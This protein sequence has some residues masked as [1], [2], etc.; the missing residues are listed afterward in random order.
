MKL[1]KKDGKGSDFEI[2]EQDELKYSFIVPRRSKLGVNIC[3][4]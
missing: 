4:I 1:Q 3:L 2:I